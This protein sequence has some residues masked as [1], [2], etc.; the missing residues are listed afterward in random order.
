MKCIDK[1][2]LRKLLRLREEIKYYEEQLVWAAKIE[3]DFNKEDVEHFKDDLYELLAIINME[4]VRLRNKLDKS[5]G[6]T[7]GGEE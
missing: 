2:R 7:L 4:A 5:N 1:Y 3:N 6:I